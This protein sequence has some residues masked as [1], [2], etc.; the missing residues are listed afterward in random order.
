MNIREPVYDNIYRI[1]MN[2]KN[3]KQLYLSVKNAWYD[4]KGQLKR[5]HEWTFNEAISMQFNS[6]KE[7]KEYGENYFKHFKN[8]YVDI[9][10]ECVG[11]I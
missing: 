2:S 6:E 11:S 9:H 10:R 8:W 3:G 7:A 4:K 1:S 5:I